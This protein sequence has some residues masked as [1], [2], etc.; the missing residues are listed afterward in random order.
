M[1]ERKSRRENIPFPRFTKVIINHFLSQYKSLFN[2]KYQ[3]YHT[4][5][6]DGI[7]SRLKFVRTE[8]DY[9]EYRLAIPDMMRSNNLNL[10]R[11][12]SSTQLVKFPPRRAE[13]KVHKGRRLHILLWQMSMCLMS[14]TLNQ[15][16]RE[17]L[18]EECLTKAAEEEAARQV[19]STHARIVTE[20]DPEPA[21]KKTGSRSK[22]SVVI[23]DTTSTKG[24]SEGT[25]R[26]PRVPDESTVI[27]ATLSEGTGTKPEVPN[28]E[29]LNERKGL[30]EKM[31][32]RKMILDDDKSID[33]EMTDGEETDD[34]VLQGKEQVN[35]DEDKDKVPKKLKKERKGDSNKAELLYRLLAYLLSSDAEISLLLDIKIQ[36][37]V[38]HIQSPSMLKV[39]MFV[40]F[41]PSVLTPVQET[42]SGAPVTTLPP[43]SVSTIPPAP[44]QQSTIPIPS[45]PITTDALTITT[46]VPESDALSV[47]QV[48]TVVE[49]YI[50]SKIR[51]DLQKVLQR[52]TADLI[53]KYS[54]K[55]AP[56]SS[57]IQTPTINLEQESEKSASEILKSKKES[58]E[59]QKMPKYTIKSTDKAALKEYDQKALSIRP[60][61]KN[62]SFKRNPANHRLYHAL[63]KALIE[64]ENVMDV[65]PR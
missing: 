32:R 43:P 2:L 3:H 62:K 34:E 41:E 36:Y 44:L 37:E 14:L 40:I 20:S 56:E 28:E 33:L 11:C 15:L 52:H 42:P 58:A 50:G 48:P 60:C 21:K 29:G 25:G 46:A 4:I 6:E 57:K 10:N 12:S 61:M 27:S 35:D 59:K 1:N 13:A 54:M 24:S 65:T 49:Q 64:D 9:Q 51:N 53:Q 39:P 45:P 47:S 30:F 38:S 55:P 17:L 23:Q 22:R 31:I 19:H 7:V 18:V 5:K 26:I 16:E 8:E 63:I